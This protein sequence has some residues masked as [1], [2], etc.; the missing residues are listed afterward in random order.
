MDCI[1]FYNGHTMIK[2]L[3]KSVLMMIFVISAG[4]K[5]YDFGNTSQ[6][7]KLISG[8]PLAIIT[9][10]LTGLILVELVIGVVVLLDGY[11]SLVIYYSIIIILILFMIINIL[12]YFNG[13]ENCGCFGTTIATPPI[14]S[15]FKSTL[16]V[17]IICH[18]RRELLLNRTP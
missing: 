6:Y 18:I 4:S 14:F 10:F 1:F 3:L 13:V 15:L 17:L 11:R 2:F 12:F 5:L 8:F 9:V 16:L 7:F